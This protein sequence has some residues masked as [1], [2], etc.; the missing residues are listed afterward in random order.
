VPQVLWMGL[1]RVLPRCQPTGNPTTAANP[2]RARAA[3]TGHSCV[4]AVGAG[5]AVA[6]TSTPAISA[7]AIAT[8]SMP[9]IGTTGDPATV[10]TAVIAIGTTGDPATV[11]TAAI[12]IGTTG[13]PATAATAAVFRPPWHGTMRLLLPKQHLRAAGRAVRGDALCDHVV[14]PG[15]WWK[16]PVL[17]RGCDCQWLPPRLP[18]D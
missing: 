5:S 7:T 14:S 11:T 3:H 17:S 18:M 6:T 13:D 1:L 16:R 10:A 12:A 9:A 8:T 4:A 2:T 15:L